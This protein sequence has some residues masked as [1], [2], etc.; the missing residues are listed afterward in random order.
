MREKQEN[1][2]QVLNDENLK[3]KEENMKIMNRILELEKS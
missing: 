1:T 3:L 2:N